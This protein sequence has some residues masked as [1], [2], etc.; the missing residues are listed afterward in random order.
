MLRR[1][2]SWVCASFLA[3][4][5][6]SLHAASF[7]VNGDSGVPG[8]S[9][10]VSLFDEQTVEFE[11]ATIEVLFDDSRLAF[12]SASLGSLLAHSSLGFLP[13]VVDSSS[14]RLVVSLVGAN[15]V[16]MSSGELLRISF[17]IVASAP[18]G[19]AFVSF[20]CLNAASCQFDYD[21]PLTIGAVAVLDPTTPIPEPSA[22]LLLAF[23]LA[24]ILLVRRK[25]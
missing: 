7:F 22:A 25:T 3:F 19:D 21:I 17:D 16:D 24:T 9:V 11:A 15:A 8:E 6:L 20:Q 13:P 5:P 14:G 10:Q 1:L 4:L 12:A 18:V 23:G 2:A